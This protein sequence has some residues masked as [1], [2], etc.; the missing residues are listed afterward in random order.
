MLLPRKALRTRCALH[1][2]TRFTVFLIQ[3]RFRPEPRHWSPCSCGVCTDLGVCNYT[4][5]NH[6]CFGPS[7]YVLPKK[8]TRDTRPL[9]YHHTIGKMGPSSERLRIELSLIPH[10]G[11]SSGPPGGPSRAHA[12]PE[13]PHDVTFVSLWVDQRP[14]RTRTSSQSPGFHP[15]CPLQVSVLEICTRID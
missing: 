5:C 8:Q 1:G 15:P 4:H 2:V 9:V 11:W 7:N 14:L 3:Q 6:H 10:A 12:R 13:V